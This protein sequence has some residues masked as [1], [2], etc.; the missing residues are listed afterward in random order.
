MLFYFFPL[1]KRC[2]FYI[3]LICFI[4]IF[5]SRFVA[6]WWQPEL[7]NRVQ[8]SVF[9]ESCFN[10]TVN[11]G[12]SCT[13]SLLCFRG[14]TLTPAS[15]LVQK[16]LHRLESNDSLAGWALG[17]FV[18]L[19]AYRSCLLSMAVIV[20]VESCEIWGPMKCFFL[21]RPNSESKRMGGFASCRS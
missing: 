13:A 14:A 15:W 19:K 5:V 3:I 11:L 10:M 17:S 20:F 1:K 9:G 12:A 21:H 16:C 7:W 4:Y 6:L 8:V 18:M 2:Q